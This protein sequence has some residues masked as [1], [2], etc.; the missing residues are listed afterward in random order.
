MS[1]RTPETQVSVRKRPSSEISVPDWK[2]SSDGTRAW[3]WDRI[4]EDVRHQTVQETLVDDWHDKVPNWHDQAP[5]DP[6]HLAYLARSRFYVLGLDVFRLQTLHDWCAEGDQDYVSKDDYPMTDAK[7]KERFGSA[8]KRDD[9]VRM[10]NT[11]VDQDKIRRKKHETESK[12]HTAL[13]SFV[14][15]IAHLSAHVPAIEWGVRG[16]VE[17]PARFADFQFLP[18]GLCRS[19]HEPIGHSYQ[20]SFDVSLRGYSFQPILAT[21]FGI[22]LT[23]STTICYYISIAQVAWELYARTNF[24][25]VLSSR[26]CDTETNETDIPRDVWKLIL[27]FIRTPPLFPALFLDRSFLNSLC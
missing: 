2:V 19:K 15:L 12:R 7:V 13:Y 26:I 16:A 22:D 27:G 25:C 1:D 17:P 4:F 23:T 18:T 3:N 8:R 20:G 6:E 14:P 11:R 24:L 5:E 21:H 9:Y 10:C